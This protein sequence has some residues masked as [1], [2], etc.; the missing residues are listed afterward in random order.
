MKRCILIL[1]LTLVAIPYAHASNPNNPTVTTDEEQIWN[2]QYHVIQAHA[3]A[4]RGELGVAALHLE[5]ARYLRPFDIEIRQG[6]DLLRQQ[7]QRQR[8]MKFQHA[9]MT[10]GE[11]NELWWWRLFH[12]M[13]SRIWAWG[14]LI[15]LWAAFV[16]W[17]IL[18]RRPSGVTRDGFIAAAVTSLVFSIGSFICWDGAIRSAKQLEPGVIV[19]RAP[20]FFTAPDSLASK[21]QSPDLYEGGVVLIRWQDDEWME[22]ELASQSRVWVKQGTVI[23]VAAGDWRQ[24][25]NETAATAD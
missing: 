11:P 18:R 22:I 23:P 14:A 9:R 2:A 5:R 12:S 6:L 25:S 21:D 19:E 17:L 10:Q 16:F 15:E 4:E 3:A 20:H 8:M 7:V 24:A 1:L 13:P